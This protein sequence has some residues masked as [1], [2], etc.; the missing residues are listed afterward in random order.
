MSATFAASEVRLGR[1]THA[2]LANCTVRINGGEAVSATF[3]NA[4]V[5]APLGAAGIYARTPRLSLPAS[6]VEFVEEGMSVEVESESSAAT[7]Y[8]VK[9][10]MPDELHTGMAMLLLEPAA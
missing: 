2:R 9:A 4:S 5:T 8:T 10:R 3:S 7:F 1:V 6:L